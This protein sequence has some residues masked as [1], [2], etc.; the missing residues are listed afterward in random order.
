MLL[1][2]PDSNRDRKDSRSLSSVDVSLINA[3]NPALKG[4]KTRRHVHYCRSEGAH[5]AR[6]ETEEEMNFIK[7]EIDVLPGQ[8]WLDGVDDVHE[9]DWRWASTFSKISSSFWYPGEPNQ[10]SHSEDCME[11]A[12]RYHGLWNDEECSDRQYSI[13][14]KETLSL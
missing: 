3:N 8:Y 1:V 14:E 12:S 4:K 13:C 9:A 5:L 11:T 10:A 6:V 7:K 2:F